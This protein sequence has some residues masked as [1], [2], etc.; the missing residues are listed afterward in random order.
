MIRPPR[1]ASSPPNTCDCHVAA[2]DL[3]NDLANKMY[4][5]T[6]NLTRHT[7]LI[8]GELSAKTSQVS[9]AELDQMFT[10]MNGG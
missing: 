8:T 7:I 2:N 9:R 4:G 10:R 5:A 1:S 6:M 3:A